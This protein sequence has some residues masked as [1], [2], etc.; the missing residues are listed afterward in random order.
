M[1]LVSK[2]AESLKDLMYDKQLTVEKLSNDIEMSGGGIY[3]WLTG[4][5]KYLPSIT[6]LLTLA[7]YFNCSVDYLVGIEQINYPPKPKP[8]PNFS[9]WFRQAIEAKG[10]NLNKLQN[11]TKIHTGNFYKWIN[12]NGEPSL[13]SLVRIAKVLDCSIDYLL[14][15]GE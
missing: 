13:D 1:E 3:A 2:F 7:D 15:R 6:S 5:S 10:Y 4:K 9:S 11:A 12:N 14:G 8:H